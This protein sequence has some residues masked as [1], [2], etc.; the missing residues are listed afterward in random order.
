[1]SEKTNKTE[2]Q[3]KFTV[4]KEI[5][6]VYILTGSENAQGTAHKNSDGQMVGYTYDIWQMVKEKLS[7]KYEFVETFSD[8]TEQNYTK[9]VDDTEEG[10]HDI[11]IGVFTHSPQ[12]AKQV[13]MSHPIMIDGNIIVHKKAEDEFNRIFF[14]VKETL[15]LLAILFLFTLLGSIILYFVEPTRTH[16]LPQYKK[17]KNKNLYTFLRSTLTVAAAS[18]GEMGYLAENSTLSLPGITVVITI[19]MVSFLLISFIQSEITAINIQQRSMSVYNKEKV[20]GAR[21]I[22]YKG[23]A[24]T[25]KFKLLG[26]KIDEVGDMTIDQIINLYKDN[27]EKYEGVVLVYSDAA[28]YPEIMNDISSSHE[29]LNKFLASWIINSKKKYFA[30][31][32]NKK[33]IEIQDNG[34]LQEICRSYFNEDFACSLN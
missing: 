26:P 16:D 24:S 32:V 21:F 29:G 12:R 11:V 25:D 27:E 22:G 15:K 31:D 2:E 4:G 5:I 7:D 19:M 9:F 18:L 33:L 34:E 13:L 20:K 14:I 3:R 1:M 10:I 28:K 23:W 17:F 30:D 8:P 6:K